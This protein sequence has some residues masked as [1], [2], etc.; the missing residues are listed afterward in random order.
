MYDE[1]YEIKEFL[2]LFYVVNK[3]I[4][5]TLNNIFKDFDIT[6]G[7]YLVLIHLKKDTLINLHELGELLRLDAGTLTPS[8]RRLESKGLVE[9]KRSFSDERK[10]GIR[11]TSEGESVLLDIENVIIQSMVIKISENTNYVDFLKSFYDKH[12]GHTK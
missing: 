7:N 1:N 6:L 2:R 4:N 8:T 3:E 11:I 9:R 5:R 12:I 10:V